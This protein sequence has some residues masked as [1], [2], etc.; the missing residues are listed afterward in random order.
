MLKKVVCHMRLVT[1]A[2]IGSGDGQ[3]ADT[4]SPASLKGALR[5]WWRA[6]RWDALLA[7]CQGDSSLALKTLQQREA[8]MFGSANAN[9]SHQSR[10]LIKPVMPISKGN[11]DL[12][13]V[14]NKRGFQYLAGLGLYHFRDGFL[15][16]ALNPFDFTLTLVCRDLDT[17]QER[18]LGEALLAMG[19]LGGIGSRA[20]KGFGSLALQSIEGLDIAVPSSPAELRATISSLG[21]WVSKALPPYTAF[22]AGS[23]IDVVS[24]SAKDALNTLDDIGQE[25]ML[26]RGFGR[27]G[28]VL[29]KVAERNF[30]ADHDN[31]QRAISDGRIDAAPERAVFG[32]PHN[33]FFSSG[34]KMDI[35]PEGY[36][37][38][39]SPLF[40]HLHE[41]K[42]GEHCVILSLLPAQ[43]LPAGTGLEFKPGS[44]RSF[45]LSASKS[46]VDWNVLHRFMDRFESRETLTK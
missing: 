29:D 39:S 40:M 27:N 5:F 15:R 1:P 3:C 35:N 11:F 9:S 24:P 14:E 43:F 16:K 28:K 42:S 7:E 32:L 6:C 17:E 34:G 21:P 37:R 20:R 22:S 46:E 38:R 2:F 44:G 41:F 19:L 13:Q 8:D 33:Y 23:R 4:L 26:Y 31:V 30:K 18:Q 10:V 25:Q 12:K 45:T 36:E